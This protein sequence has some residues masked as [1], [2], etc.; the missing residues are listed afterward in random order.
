[1]A[2][3]ARASPPDFE[4]TARFGYIAVVRRFVFLTVSLALAAPASAGPGSITFIN[5]TGAPLSNLQVRKTGKAWQ[6]LT[7][8]LS[9]GA[10]TTADL[11]GEDCAYDVR[12]NAGAVG[13]VQWDRLNL[14]EVRSVTLNRRADGTSWA[15][16]D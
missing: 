16:Y 13:A 10:R 6:P 12:G 7:S 11:A 4:G 15:D 5:G 2:A 14:C 9:P 3:V 1:V 8:G